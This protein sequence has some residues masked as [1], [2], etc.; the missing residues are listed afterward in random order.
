[1][2]NLS[3][4]TGRNMSQSEQKKSTQD[5]TVE[6][7]AR[8]FKSS[9]PNLKM[10]PSRADELLMI[11]HRLGEAIDTTSEYSERFRVHE[12][13]RLNLTYLR[14]LHAVDPHH[15]FILEDKDNI[16]GFMLSG[17]EFGTLWL[18]WSYVFPEFRRASLAMSFLPMFCEYWNNR[19]FHK[20]AT[21]SLEDNKVALALMKRFKFEMICVLKQHLFGQDF[22]LWERQLTKTEDGYDNGI[23]VGTKTRI[24]RKIRSWFGR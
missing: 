22:L 17:P 21:Y 10:R 19:R 3:Q 24:I 4:Q 20:I 8:A 5:T 11:H 9:N 23:D 1:M 7:P 12:K 6:K 16:I 13:A 2:E 18:Y 15:V 14:N